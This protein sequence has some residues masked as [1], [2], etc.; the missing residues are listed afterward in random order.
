MNFYLAMSLSLA[1]TIH[2]VRHYDFGLCVT[3]EVRGIVLTPLNPD[4]VIVCIPKRD[5]ADLTLFGESK[6]SGQSLA[7]N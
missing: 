5:T 6:L 1:T 4:C 3:N 2:V 7:L